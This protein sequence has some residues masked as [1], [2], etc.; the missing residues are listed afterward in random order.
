MRYALWLVLT[1]IVNRVLI[2]S[3]GYVH[4][5]ELTPANAPATSEG[6][7]GIFRSSPDLGVKNLLAVSKAKKLQKKSQNKQSDTLRMYIYMSMP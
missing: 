6:G 4:S 7:T 2:N 5:V 3:R 1:C